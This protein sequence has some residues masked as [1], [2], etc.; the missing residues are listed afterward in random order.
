[1]E[2]EEL[3][4]SITDFIQD[5]KYG[6]V[7]Q[8]MPAYVNRW[9]RQ[10]ADADQLTVLKEMNNLIARLYLPREEVKQF[11]KNFL[12]NSRICSAEPREKLR[13]M[14]FLRMEQK[15]RNQAE[16]LKLAD[17][18]LQEEISLRVDQCGGSND[19]MYLDDCIFR[20]NR[21]RQDLV[22]W[23]NNTAFKPGATII[24]YH[25]ARH[26]KGYEDATLHIK[27]AAYAKRVTVIFCYSKEIAPEEETA[28]HKPAKPATEA[29]QLGIFEDNGR[30]A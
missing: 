8:G 16:M 20:G 22:T 12:L 30:F 3:L 9:I 25:V 11:L 4:T 23:I 1:M 2:R 6:V 5:Y 17:E 21:F 19:F 24:T 13:K 10:F 28:G 26:K 15:S 14:N 7:Q 27:K 29:Q 18:I